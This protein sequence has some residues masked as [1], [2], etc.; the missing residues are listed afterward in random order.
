MVRE[1]ILLIKTSRLYLN[2]N[3]RIGIEKRGTTSQQFL[4]KFS[5]GLTTL[6]ADNI[7]NNNVPLLNM[8][9]E[10]DWVLNSLAFDST[11]IRDYLSYSLYSDLGNYSPRMQYCEVVV[12]GDYKGLYIFMEKIKVDDGRVNIVKMAPT[13]IALPEVSGGFITKCDKTTGGDPVAWTMS[14]YTGGSVNF[15]HDTPDPDVHNGTATHLYLQSIRL[16]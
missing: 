10:N 8:P 14:S 4:N 3:G 5:Y 13:D 12:N 16:L 2:Y 15:I 1:I 11:L 6:L 9:A 7:T